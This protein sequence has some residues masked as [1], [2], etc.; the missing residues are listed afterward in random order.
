[1]QAVWCDRLDAL[2]FP[3]PNG[4]SC[5]IHRLALRALLGRG[6]TPERCMDF[7]AAHISRL[8]DA[9]MARIEHNSIGEGRNF[10]LNS[11]HLRSTLN[12]QG[13]CV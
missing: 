8:Q 2:Q 3:A 13:T 12:W 10:H 6:L 9:A 4:G 7:A 5:F 1:M 11:R